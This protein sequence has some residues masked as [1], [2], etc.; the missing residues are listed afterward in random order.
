MSSSNFKGVFVGIVLCLK[1]RR[2]EIVIFIKCVCE[3]VGN[4]I[5]KLNK[6]L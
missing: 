6:F 3:S 1:V 4:K 5:G 2:L